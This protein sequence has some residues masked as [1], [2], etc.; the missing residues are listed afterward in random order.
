MNT[1]KAKLPT[2]GGQ[3]LIEGVLMRGSSYVAAAF[4]TPQGEIALQSEKLSGIYSSRIRSIPFL[5]GLIILWDALGLGVRYLTISANIQSGEDERIEGPTLYLTLGV[6]LSLSILLFFLAPATIG[7]LGE[8][9]LGISNWMS[10]LIEGIVRL[11]IVILYIWVIGRMPEIKRVFQYHGAEHKT[12]NAFEAGAELTP[13]TVMNYP[14]EHPRC[15]TGFLLTL[16]VFSILLFSALGPLPVA[17]RLGS[18]ILLLPVL[19]MV[20]YEYIR[21]TASR[22][23]MPLVRALIWPN[24]ALQR[25]TTVEPDRTIVEVSIAAFNHLFALEQGKNEL[26]SEKLI[27]LPNKQ[28]VSTEEVEY[29]RQ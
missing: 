23:N 13:D 10:N 6:S 27:P 4:R 12:I 2:Y 15:G 19:A 22:L 29:Q 25:L 14:L 20:A 8:R 7:H 28:P 18:R 24:L 1:N 21:F 9:Y 26:P 16:V 11:M 5:R 17:L 3:A